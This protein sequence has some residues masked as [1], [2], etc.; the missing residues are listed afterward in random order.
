M[1]NN[2]NKEIVICL[3][4][5]TF[6]MNRAYKWKCVQIATHVS[7]PALR[8]MHAGDRPLLALQGT[9]DWA[10]LYTCRYLFQK[11]N[12]VEY[13]E[14]STICCAL[15]ISTS[16]HQMSDKNVGYV[17]YFMPQKEKHT[18][19]AQK[20]GSN[21]GKHWPTPS[22]EATEHESFDSEPDS[23]T[24]WNLSVDNVPSHFATKY[25]PEKLY[26]LVQSNP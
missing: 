8:P 13:P 9:F 21:G 26:H 16:L 22:F 14:N 4:G 1:R 24:L 6:V 20:L 25:L 7:Q 19:C 11:L 18:N 17:S 2:G 5:R 10:V 3:L 23:T 15:S 12:R